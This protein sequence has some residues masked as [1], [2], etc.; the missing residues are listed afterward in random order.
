ML[1][2]SGGSPHSKFYYLKHIQG[3]SYKVTCLRGFEDAVAS[4]YK[5]MAIDIL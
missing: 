4:I 3:L 1:R 2:I 5:F